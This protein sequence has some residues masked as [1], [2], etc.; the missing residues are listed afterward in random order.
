MTLSEDKDALAIL[1]DMLDYAREVSRFSGGKGLSE[2]VQD[3]MYQFAVLRGLEIVG[4]GA[5][6][7]PERI[8]ARF[9]EVP[10]VLVAGLRNVLAHE[11]SKIQL[12]RVEEVLRNDLPALIESLERMIR[13]IEQE[14]EAPDR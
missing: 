5:R 14:S 9:P 8:R 11:Y 1:E 3:K 7:I 12:D 4:E 6:R 13:C 10:W 2:L